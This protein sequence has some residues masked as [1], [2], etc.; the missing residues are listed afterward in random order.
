MKV[1]SPIAEP[2]YLPPALEA[3][4]LVPSKLLLLTY[5]CLTVLFG[6]KRGF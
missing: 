1:L 3:W 2:K 4:I 5:L 6:N